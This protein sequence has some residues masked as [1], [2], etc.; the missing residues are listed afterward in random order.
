MTWTNLA[1][2]QQREKLQAYNTVADAVQLIK[3]A[4]K[5]VILTGAGISQYSYFWTQVQIHN[6]TLG[7]SCGIPDFRSKD[8]L[9]AGLKERTEYDLDDPQQ[10]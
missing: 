7:V 4:N 1:R 5:I 6:M 9:Y 2:L 8:G 10:M 3:A